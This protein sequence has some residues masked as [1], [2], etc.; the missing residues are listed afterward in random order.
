MFIYNSYVLNVG[1]YLG[2]K[3]SCQGD[4]GNSLL[5]WFSLNKLY[6]RFNFFYSITLVQDIVN[7]KKKFIS[8]GIVSYGEGCAREYLPGIYTK[9]SYFMSWILKHLWSK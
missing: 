4:S 9:V 8:I 1:D 3:D 2:G 5:S 7:G 6:N